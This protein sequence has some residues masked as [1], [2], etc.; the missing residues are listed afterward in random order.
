MGCRCVSL[1]VGRRGCMIAMMFFYRERREMSSELLQCLIFDHGIL[2]FLAWDFEVVVHWIEMFLL[3]V[4]RLHYSLS[5]PPLRQQSWSE[6]PS[7]LYHYITKVHV[8]V[9]VPY[10][11]KEGRIV[12]ME[13]RSCR[14]ANR[15]NYVLNPKF[16]CILDDHHDCQYRLTNHFPD[17]SS[18]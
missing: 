3:S 17:Q 12:V 8:Y 2:D 6:A 4:A 9:G 16:K 14:V 15:I 1:G 13:R 7:T 11:E 10:L 5:L 18:I